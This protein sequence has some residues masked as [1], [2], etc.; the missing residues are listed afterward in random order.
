MI[1]GKENDGI[2][3]KIIKKDYIKRYLFLIIGCFLLAFSFNV[4]F[5]PYNVVTGGIPGIAIVLN[6]AFGISTSLFISISYVVLLILSFIILGKETTK[7]S[8][9][10]TLLYP[11]FV[12][13]T[14]DV[15]KFIE[16]DV[17]SI[18]LVAVFGGIIKGIG[19]GL[20]FKYGFS[21]GGGD[22]VC[23]IMSKW[24][25]IS[26]GNAMKIFNFIIIIGSGFFLSNNLYAWE[27]VMY[28]IISA[29][30]STLLTDRVLLG[31]SSC[32]AFYVI[33]THETA[34]KKFLMNEIGRGVTVLEARGG[35]TG[36]MKKVLMCAVPTRDYFLAKEGIL[37]ID[38]DAFILINDVYQSEG[39]E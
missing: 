8:I 30:I 32:K 37:E 1:N 28:A 27:N 20:T 18:L 22:V 25:K 17:N 12:Y 2:L 14:K 39:I 33:T 11:V 10:G 19:S 26:I 16:F 35:Y 9:I 4:F 34:I 21:T 7:N 29:Y 36:D 23:Q 5:S 24:F 15:G 3:N 31:I 6:N 38:K 13:L